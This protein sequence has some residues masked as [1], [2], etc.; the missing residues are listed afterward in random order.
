[1]PIIEPTRRNCLQIADFALKILIEKKFK[2]IE[3]VIKKFKFKLTQSKT[4]K[5]KRYIQIY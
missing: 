2:I 4:L 5:T 3:C 1:M